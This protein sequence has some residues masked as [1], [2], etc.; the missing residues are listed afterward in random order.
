MRVLLDTHALLWWLG[1]DRRLGTTARATISDPGNDVLVST[2]S[3]WEIVIKSR[4]G[5]LRANFGAIE[6]AIIRDG[7]QRLAITS[8]HLATLASL[9]MHHRDPFDHLLIAQALA[10][11]AVFL[12]EDQN[13]ASYPVQLQPC[14]DASEA[15]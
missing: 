7:F 6:G 1:D 9:P 10:E 11:N 14:T 15:S 12:S 13:A 8:P 4:I 2:V 3:L 5:K